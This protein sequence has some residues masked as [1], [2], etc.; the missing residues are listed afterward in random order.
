MRGASNVIRKLALPNS[1][2][3]RHGDF[4][5]RAQVDTENEL[6]DVDGGQPAAVAAPWTFGRW[7]VIPRC[8]LR[9]FVRLVTAD[10]ISKYARKLTEEL[11]VSS[12]SS[13]WKASCLGCLVLGSR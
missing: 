10:A 12:R 2:S 7:C 11:N 13:D 4:F 3:A 1:D 6:E 9:L 5:D 8:C